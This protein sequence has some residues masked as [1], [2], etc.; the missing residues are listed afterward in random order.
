MNVKNVVTGT[1]RSVTRSAATDRFFELASS[2]VQE[3]VRLI[4]GGKPPRHYSG[5]VSGSISVKDGSEFDTFSWSGNVRLKY[6]GDLE[7]ENGGDPPG[8]YAIYEPESGSIHVIVDGAS[9]DGQCPYHGEADVTIVPTPGEQHSRVQQGVDQPTYSLFAAYPTG[10]PPMPVTGPAICAGGFTNPRPLADLLFMSTADEPALVV[11][12]AGRGLDRRER[13]GNDQGGV[14]AGAGGVRFRAR[15]YADFV[16]SETY[17]IVGA[18]LAG[19]KAAE[20]LRE[21]GFDGRVV[22]L[23]DEPDRPYERPPLSKDYL[24]GETER[25]GPYVHP[26]SFYGEKDIELRTE[27]TRDRGRPLGGRG[28]HRGRAAGVLEAAA[29]HRRRAAPAAGAGRRPRRRPLPAH[30]SATATRCAPRSRRAAAWP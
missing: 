27:V 4:C 13:P 1:T 29:R 6:T 10:T 11:D 17:V 9:A 5:P 24:R 20:T 15:R 23:G 18:A 30:A 12:D 21:E 19:A 16:V 3:V 2:V 25:E 22:L 28:A 14:V 26:A 7:P 8:E